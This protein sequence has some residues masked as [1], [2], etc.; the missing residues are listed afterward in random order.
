[1]VVVGPPRSWRKL[2]VRPPAASAH[3]KKLPAGELI[4]VSPTGRHRYFRLAS[5]EVAALLERTCMDW[6]ERRLHLAGPLG[7]NLA[8]FLLTK[9][10]LQRDS[11]SRALTVIPG[12]AECLRTMFEI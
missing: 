2:R 8:Q 10:I 7:R 12:G 5:A 9:K 3:L 4:K 6:S 1:M 11:K